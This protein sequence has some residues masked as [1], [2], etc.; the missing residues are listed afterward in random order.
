M[1][2]AV[3][4]L[5]KSRRSIRRYTAQAIAPDVLQSILEAA[6]WAPSAHNRQPW[7]FAVVETADIKARL[8]RQ[9][10]ER[11]RRD[12]LADGDPVE[13]IEADVSR[14]Y[15][16]I[17]GAAVAVLVCVSM[18]DMDTYPD[19][20]RQAAERQMAIQ[21]AAMAAQNMLLAAHSLG[22]GACWLCAP[23]FV[24]DTV[25]AS[26]DLPLDWEPQG[27][28]TLGYPDGPAKVRGRNA[29][30]TVAVWR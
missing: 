29:L 18:R 10:G 15:T 16:R 20:R 2:L 12:R 30:E 24:P 22:V 8:A 1:S 19:P 27:L 7:R 23:L 28:I 17:A 6:I 21:G 26:L 25:R 11:L 14:S 3:L 5:L 13:V 4:D 9:M